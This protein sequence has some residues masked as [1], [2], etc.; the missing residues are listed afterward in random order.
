MKRLVT[1]WKYY[2]LYRRPY[3]KALAKRI[4]ELKKIKGENNG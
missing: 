2:Y 4:D 1:R 3:M